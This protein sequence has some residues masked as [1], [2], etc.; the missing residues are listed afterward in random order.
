MESL[1]NKDEELSPI[2]D[3]L[4]K[5]IVMTIAT[6]LFSGILFLVVQI[7]IEVVSIFTTPAISSF[8]SIWPH[9]VLL[10]FAIVFR[11][12]YKSGFLDGR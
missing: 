11:V 6:G 7:V 3:F 1:K 4:V 9:L 8:T 12:S 10:A 2:A 5:I